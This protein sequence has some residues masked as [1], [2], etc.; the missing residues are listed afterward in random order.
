MGC[1]VYSTKNQK[2]ISWPRASVNCSFVT[3]IQF[4]EKLTVGLRVAKIGKRS[5]TLRF[6]FACGEREIA[7][8]EM[9]TV[10]C[11]VSGGAF[12]SIDIPPDIRA[13][14]EAHPCDP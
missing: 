14:L 8:G 9:K 3:P 10:C 6:D 13:L 11:E 1:S 7:H 2:T 4:E 5:L 12:G